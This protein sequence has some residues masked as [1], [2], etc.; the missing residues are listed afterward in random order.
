MEI[1]LIYMNKLV[2]GT[3][4]LGLKYGKTNI[5]GKPSNDD[6]SEIIKYAVKNNVKMFDTARA[7]TH[8]KSAE[9]HLMNEITKFIND[10]KL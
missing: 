4:Q 1:N 8:D 7:L 5:T 9:K 3:A 6:S 2:V 10:L